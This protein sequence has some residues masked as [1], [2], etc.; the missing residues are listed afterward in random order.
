MRNLEQRIAE[1]NRR[2]EKLLKQRKQRRIHT[3]TACVSL[4][5]CIGLGSVFVLPE[6]LPAKNAA[7]QD[8]NA[9]GAWIEDRLES[10]TS[11][12]AKIQV[13]GMGVSHSITDPADIL[14]V[15][16]YLQSLRIVAVMD[17][18][19]NFADMNGDYEET[20]RGETGATEAVD[21]ES[22]DATQTGYLITRVMHTGECIQYY[23]AGNTLV[24]ESTGQTVILAPRQIK[25]L[26]NLLGIS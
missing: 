14:R 21:E 25:N 2:S 23:F 10:Q 13:D 18:S 24:D 6:I 9:G 11:S 19:D 4:A 3:L 17:S 7:P 1:I 12:V 5:I 15:V 16:N 22:A 26:K 8:P 20:V